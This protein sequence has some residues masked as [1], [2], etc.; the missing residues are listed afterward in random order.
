LTGFSLG[1]V[2]RFS[3]EE[4]EKKFAVPVDTVFWFPTDEEE[5]T[6]Y[7]KMLP[8]LKKSLS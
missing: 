2:G 5:T 8:A 4:D 7:D 6:W 3:T 1:L